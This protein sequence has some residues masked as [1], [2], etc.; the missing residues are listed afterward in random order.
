MKAAINII[1]GVLILLW[2][3]LLAGNTILYIDAS[4]RGNDPPSIA[5][6]A[7]YTV[8][9]ETMRPD[10]VAGDLAIIKL[11]GTAKPGD[12]V[13]HDSSLKRII[14]TSEEKFIL[15]PDGADSSAL[16]EENEI[17]GVLI[18]FIPGIGKAAEFMRSLLGLIATGAVGLG[19]FVL[20]I[21]L[22]RPE[23]P[24][25][26][27]RTDKVQPVKPARQHGSGY[28]PRH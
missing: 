11:E 12:V 21:I 15:K 2:A 20:S 18:T 13:Y 4:V 7:V 1:R 14:G 25:R 8:P 26:P 17:D 28:K 24:D 19:L 27:L 10:L 23:K 16:A 22:M 3:L 6:Y 5:N 9:D